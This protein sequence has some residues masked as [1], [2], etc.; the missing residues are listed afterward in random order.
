MATLPGRIEKRIHLEI[1]VEVSR[2]QSPGPGDFAEKAT[3]ENVSSG[4]VRV[5]IKR[6]L[7]PDERLQITLLVG[8]ERPTPARVVYCQ[9]LAGA[10][11]GLG[12][13]F[14]EEVA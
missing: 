10:L 13:Q 8:S 9:P 6:A 2:M 3:T 4:G 1:P 11:F 5:L 14:E 7:L 12:L